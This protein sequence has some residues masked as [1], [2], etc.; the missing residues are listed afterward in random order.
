[1]S[2]FVFKDYDKEGFE[3]LKTIAAADQFNEWMYQ[4]IRPHCRGKILEVGSGI[5]NISKFFIRDQAEIYLSDLRDNYLDYLKSTYGG[6]VLDILNIDL[7]NIDF[8]TLHVDLKG[9][10]DTVF[11]LNVIEHIEEDLIALRNIKKILRP[12]GNVVILVPAFNFLYNN[13]DHKLG[14]YRRYNRRSLEALLKKAEFR[15]SYSSY[16][17]VAGMLGWILSGKLLRRDVIPKGQMTMFNQLVPFFK[18]LDHVAMGRLG[19]SVVVV[20]QS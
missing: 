9:Q 17:N 1:M 16:F 20:G 19:L 6:S 12:T 7:V 3:T 14:H 11:A 8:D 13:F 10:F 18:L 4:K 15:I 5:G 2:E